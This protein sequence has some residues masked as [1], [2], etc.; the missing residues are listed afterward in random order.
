MLWEKRPDEKHVVG[1]VRA[2]RPIE[3]DYRVK[4]STDAHL[5]A[6][7]ANTAQAQVISPA[8][9]RWLRRM[10]KA[11]VM[12]ERHCISFHTL[13]FCS[14]WKSQIDRAIDIHQR[15]SIQ[16]TNEVLQWFL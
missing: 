7:T 11:E 9:K 1:E 12:I 16:S 15:L 4:S 10:L 6:D 3:I 2:L 13:V 14:C 8:K 5:S